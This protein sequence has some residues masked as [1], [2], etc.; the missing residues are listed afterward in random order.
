MAD[1]VFKKYIVTIELP[2]TMGIADMARYIREAVKSDR[3]NYY[4]DDPRY[5]VDES[6][7]TVMPIPGVTYK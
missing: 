3:G 5:D 4:P 6:T 7:V 2:D 1:R